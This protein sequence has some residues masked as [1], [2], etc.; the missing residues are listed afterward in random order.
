MPPADPGPRPHS[1]A[2]SRPRPGGPH[3]TGSDVR[4]GPRRDDGPTD[5]PRL[6]DRLRAACRRRHYSYHTERAYAHWAR[7][8]CLFHRGPDG[9]PRHPETLA[10]PDLAAFLSHLAED[11]R[12]SAST[13]N[14]ALHAVLFL[15]EHVL[16]TPL[17][18]V[19]GVAR[20]KRPKR[21]PVVLSRGEVG[22]VLAALSGTNRLLAQLLYGSGLRLREGL[23]LRVHDLDPD[24]G[25]LTVREGKGGKDR[26]TVLASSVEAPLARHLA[27]ERARYEQAVD[28]GT[29]AVSLPGALGAKYPGAAA[30]W[31]WR[32]VFCARRPSPDPRTGALRLHHLG[33]SGVQKAVR[34]A[35]KA[36]GVDRPVTP[37]VFRHSFATHMLER[38]AD[39]RTV[40]E[41]LGHSDVRTTEIY[42][43]VLDRGVRGVRSPLDGLGP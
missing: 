21:L 12:V 2:P 31:G 8:Y 27:T 6:L 37:H 11:R 7:R 9:R 36:A 20:A 32:Y 19:E 14:Q 39:I 23:R 1:S 26:V 40:Q 17:G 43:H 15:Y 42:T 4:D 25:R 28:D 29:A 18:R 16:G 34:R 22:A 24:R 5:G 38:G 35:A 41:L 10:E 13:Q 33:P 3:E 30:E